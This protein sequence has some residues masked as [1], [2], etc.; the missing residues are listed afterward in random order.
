MGL[1]SAMKLPHWLMVVG[2]ILV[3][4]GLVG[5]VIRKNKKAARDRLPVGLKV[6]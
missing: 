5:S 4:I 3:A 2:V 1:F 6:K